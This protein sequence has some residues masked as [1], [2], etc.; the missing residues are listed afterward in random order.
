MFREAHQVGKESEG[1]L[2]RAKGK[3][4]SGKDGEVLEESTGEV[5]ER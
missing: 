5:E 3:V 4:P 2:G 1:I